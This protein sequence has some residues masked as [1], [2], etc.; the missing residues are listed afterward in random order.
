MGNPVAITNSNSTLSLKPA[1]RGT[2]GLD[3]V[4][5]WSNT[6]SSN[7]HVNFWNLCAEDVG[8][9]IAEYAA[10]LAVILVIVMG[11]ISGATGLHQRHT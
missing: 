4:P 3:S 2:F 11:P 5:L 6:R 7:I 1:G 9:D 8:Q 10:M